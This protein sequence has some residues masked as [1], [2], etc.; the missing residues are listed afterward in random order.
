MRLLLESARW[1]FCYTWRVH[2]NLLLAIIL[3]TVC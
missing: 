1:A 2:K 3:V